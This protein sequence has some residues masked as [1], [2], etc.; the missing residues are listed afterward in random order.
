MSAINSSRRGIN[1]HCEESTMKYSL[2]RLAAVFAVL[3]PAGALLGALVADSVGRNAVGGAAVG[4][5]AGILFGLI[6]CGEMKSGN[7]FD[8]LFPPR[9]AVAC[10]CCER[11]AR[12]SLEACNCNVSYC[13]QCLRC[14]THCDCMTVRATVLVDGSGRVPIGSPF[15]DG[16]SQ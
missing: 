6:A 9:E 15:S 11:R 10:S 7:L 12:D 1:R 14:A 16:S 4:G 5:V 13:S 8:A 3:S 2:A